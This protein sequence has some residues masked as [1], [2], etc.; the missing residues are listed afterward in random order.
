MFDDVSRCM[1]D[2]LD[3]GQTYGRRLDCCSDYKC[4][5]LQDDRAQVTGGTLLIARGRSKNSICRLSLFFNRGCETPPPILALG[6]MPPRDLPHSSPPRVHATC[7]S[8]WATTSPAV[9]GR[10]S[11]AS[12]AECMAC[13]VCGSSQG[14]W[15]WGDSG[16]CHCGLR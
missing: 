3:L 7:G 10:A 14:C 11:W 16:S 15:T 9:P 4:A 5:I 1:G 8:D 13:D 6:I 2:V 12:L